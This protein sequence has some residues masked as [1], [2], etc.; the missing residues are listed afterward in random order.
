MLETPQVIQTTTQLTAAIHLTIPRDQIEQAMCPAVSEVM[1]AIA[2]QGIAPVGPVFSYHFRIE[3]GLFDFE[4]G[5]PV[6]RPVAAAGRV[7]P[8]QLPAAKVAMAAYRGP[9]E[10]LGGAWGAWGELGAWIKANGHTPGAGLW[11]S[12]A[13]GPESGP[14]PASWRTELHRVLMG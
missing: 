7:K 13:V 10:G 4:V 1:A 6:G 11:E 2:A 12:Y 8:S 3:P 9:Y 5:V 14:D